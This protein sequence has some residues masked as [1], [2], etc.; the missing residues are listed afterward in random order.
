[1]PVGG[2]IVVFAKCPT[3][4]ATKTRLIPL[5]G[6]DGAAFLAEA[7]LS[8]ILVSLSECQ[9][10]E[11]TLKV[12]MYAPGTAA[13][14]AQLTS[15]LH[16]LNI[17]H[18]SSKSIPNANQWHLIPMISSPEKKLTG[19]LTSS[20]AHS[21]LNSS[22]LGEKLIDALERVRALLAS[23]IEIY[24]HN[25]S[26]LFLGMDSP[27]IPIE[28][29]TYGLH[30]SSGKHTTHQTVESG[31]SRQFSG[32]AHMCPANDGGYGLLSVPI[33]APT[34][35]FSGV[36]WST[37]LTAVSQLKALTDACVDIS[38]GQLM[39]DIDEPEDVHLLVDR[40]TKEKGPNDVCAENDVLTKSS[41]ND[42]FDEH[43]FEKDCNGC[44]RTLQMLIK[45]GLVK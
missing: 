24:Q 5:L 26:V 31:G 8:D 45:L 10:L 19:V 33:H 34:S 29:V 28:E 22:S 35:I 7:M 12:L 27:E 13:A 41:R 23:S 2:A 17:A 16:T 15:I 44:R 38:I 14:E 36:R 25:E 4:G 9:E 43:T 37:Q 21:D 40:L 30:I 32:K 39:F 20:R 3:P 1:M 18:Y 42:I 6:E 11:G